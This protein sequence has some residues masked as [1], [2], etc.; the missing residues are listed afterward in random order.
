MKY[1]HLLAK[2]LRER[3]IRQQ[4]GWGFLRIAKSLRLGFAPKKSKAQDRLQVEVVYVVA[5]KDVYTLDYSISSL[6]NLVD[7]E[8][9]RVVLIGPGGSNVETYAASK[10]LAFFDE[11]EVIGF[12]PSHYRYPEPKTDRSGWL[13]QQLLKLAWARMSGAQAYVIVDA[14]TI[15]VNPVQF[16]VNQTYQLY[17]VEEWNEAYSR[18]V[19]RLLGY[20]DPSWLS[21]VA[22]MMIFDVS[23]VLELLRDLEKR[24]GRP[25]HEAIASTRDLHPRSCFSEY[26]LYSVWAQHKHP[27]LCATRPLYNRSAARSLLHDEVRFREISKGL[28]TIS[29]H[30]HVNDSHP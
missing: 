22:H 7:L 29:M 17:M 30:S 19:K 27:H 15:F 12:G 9:I 28:Q 21:F 20:S 14:D 23:M 5:D 26:Q 11:L 16:Y 13:Y 18:A 4:L 10:K 1:L 6:N 2:I 25:W 3:G 24:H 8:I